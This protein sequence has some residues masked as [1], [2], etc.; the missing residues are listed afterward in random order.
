MRH[1]PISPLLAL[2]CLLAAPW[3]CGA[4]NWEA[5]Q[6][7]KRADDLRIETAAKGT[8]DY[9]KLAYTSTDG[10]LIPAYLFKPLARTPGKVAAV[11]YVHGS[12]HGQF[13]SRAFP[14]VADL[15]KRGYVVLAPDYR[16]SSGYTQEFNDSADYGG[17]EIDDMLAARNYLAARPEVDA[18]RIAILGLSHGGYNTLMAL[19][20]W[21]DQFAAGVDFFGPTDLVWRVTATREENPNAEP[22]DREYFQR[23]VGKSLD[24]AP[25][26]YRARSPRF[27][28]EQI[29][30]PLLIL[31]GEKDSIVRVQ[32]SVWLAEALKNAG[33]TNFAFHIIKDGEHG[34]PA[35]QMDEAWQLAFEFLE[36]MLRPRVAAGI[37]T[38]IATGIAP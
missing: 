17:K 11:I 14:R 24:E 18:R 19:A 36:R 12:Q 22:G 13:N 34:Y 37:A 5:G 9:Q 23:M 6:A 28:A 38:E 35:P 20:K 8:L 26:L 30:A 2:G 31:H 15:V 3:L 29:S 7:E 33:K 16:S 27:I 1:G 32:E 25:A 10:L 21:P 4:G